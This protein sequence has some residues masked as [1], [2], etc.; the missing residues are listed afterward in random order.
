MKFLIEY[1][2]R[3]GLIHPLLEDRWREWVRKPDLIAKKSFQ[4]CSTYL[5]R[6][7]Y[8]PGLDVRGQYRIGMQKKDPTIVNSLFTPHSRVWILASCHYF[9]FQMKVTFFWWDICPHDNAML[10]ALLKYFWA[11]LGHFWNSSPYTHKYF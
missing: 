8:L 1:L 9:N 3:V 4:F 5:T 10:K 7:L 2:I 6:G 11:F